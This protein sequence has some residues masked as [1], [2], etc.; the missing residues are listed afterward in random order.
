MSHD[1]A[2]EFMALDL[3]GAADAALAAATAAGAEHVDVRVERV[4]RGFLS[5]RDGMRENASDDVDLG[6]SVRVLRNGTWG[7]VAVDEVSPD[8]AAA[9][10]RRA[11]DL[12]N[13]CAPLATERVELAAE[14]TYQGTWVSDYETDPFDVPERERGSL[15]AEW[16]AA[17]LAAGL[18]HSDARLS[19][20]Q[21]Q[22][23]LAS[24]SGTRVLQQRVRTELDVT[25]VLVTDDGF[26][27]MRT[28][29]PPVGRGWEYIVGGVLWDWASELERLPELLREKVSSPSVEP[30]RYTLVLDPT[31]LWL[32]IHESVGH[33]TELDRAL[34]YEANYAGTS[35]ATIDQLGALKYGSELMH[36]TGD[37]VTPNGLATV[38]WD[39]EGV[40]AQSWDLVRDGVLVGYQLDRA[41]AAANGFGRSNGCAYA[42]GAHLIP[43]QRMPNVSLQPDVNGP[44]RAGLISGVEDGI[45]IVGDK[46]W[47]ID[48]QR[49]NFQFTGQQFHRI[50]NGQ[51]V[52][53]VKDVAYQARTPDFWGS[54]VALGG[55]STY[56]LGGALN[57]GKGQ[58]GQAAA[59]SHGCPAAVFD[60]I[61]VLNTV[62]EAGR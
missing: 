54:L 19:H 45:L 49:Y 39:D 12:A 42:D 59:V 16:T 7:F 55:P 17:L 46:S 40:A 29:A 38:G 25:G 9:A 2:A 23:F 26:D 60:N 3:D 14:P 6:L 61:N 8:A 1:V 44:D 36:I 41:M 10:A 21:E 52:G 13:V 31:N 34:G 30:G 43:M 58:P 51:L 50:R 56:L 33:A 5:A 48:M 47:S 24:S 20:V 4:R 53:Q 27:D 32:T 62:A 15:I 37:R 11:V 28:V 18:T 22:K 35:F 57:C